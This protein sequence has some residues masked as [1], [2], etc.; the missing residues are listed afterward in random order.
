MPRRSH[1]RKR[2]I[3]GRCIDCGLLAEHGKLRCGDCLETQ[4]LVA[5][6]T[7]RKGQKAREKLMQA[8]PFKSF[9]SRHIR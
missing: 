1:I 6:E 8:N 9:K 4:N 3:E 7:Y 5:K 2:M